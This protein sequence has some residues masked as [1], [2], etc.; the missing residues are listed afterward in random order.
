MIIWFTEHVFEDCLGGQWHANAQEITS[1]RIWVYLG[2]I[3]TCCARFWELF[4]WSDDDFVGNH[5]LYLKFECTWEVSGF[6]EYIFENYFGVHGDTLMPRRRFTPNLS[7]PTARKEGFPR[8]PRSQKTFRI[9]RYGYGLAASEMLYWLRI[10]CWRAGVL[11]LSGRQRV[12]NWIL[13]TV[14]CDLEGTD[15]R[16]TSRLATSQL[17][18]RILWLEVPA[19]RQRRERFLRTW[20]SWESFSPCR[21]YIQICK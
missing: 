9:P 21:R 18:A 11:F 2:G 6:A 14:P 10:G 1:L 12:Y 19:T 20:F 17:T 16:R 3:S 4:R 15:Q 13:T 7:V 5:S 8:K